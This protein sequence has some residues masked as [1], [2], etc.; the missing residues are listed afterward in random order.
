MA[1]I[2]YADAKPWGTG[3]RSYIGVYGRKI[4]FF[5]LVFNEFEAADITVVSAT[6]GALCFLDTRDFAML[7]RA[8]NGGRPLPR[9][10]KMILKNDRFQLRVVCVER[11]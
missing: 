10:G 5:Y 3:V 11:F 6:S 7:H 1:A 4:S 9:S 2:S 8:F